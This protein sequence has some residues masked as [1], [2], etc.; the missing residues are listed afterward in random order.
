MGGNSVTFTLHSLPG[1]I[2]S[3]YEFGYSINSP[4]P[5]RQVKPEW[6]IWATRVKPYIP[7]FTKA[8]M[9]LVRVDRTYYYPFFYGN[10]KWRQLDSGNMDKYLFDVI[11][12]KVGINDLFFK[13]GMTD[14]V[15]SDERKV[16]V[17][18]TEVTEGEWR[19]Q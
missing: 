18:L 13:K 11:A 9:S 7:S 17:T 14:S 12:A 6:L 1:S 3:I 2:N 4:R 8:E 19:R 10:G 5:V 16:I 15:D